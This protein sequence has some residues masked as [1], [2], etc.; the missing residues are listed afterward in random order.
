M[1]QAKRAAGFEKITIGDTIQSP[2]SGET[3]ELKFIDNFDGDSLNMDWWSYNPMVFDNMEEEVYLPENV[4]VE[5]SHLILTARKTEEE[6]T[7]H[8]HGNVPY[9]SHYTS[10][11]IKSQGKVAFKFG[12]IEMLARLPYSQGMWP[13]FWMMGE[14]RGWPWGGEIDIME[15]VGGTD[16]WNNFNRDGTISA[17][18]HWCDPDLEPKDAWGGKASHSGAGKYDMPGKMEGE[19]LADAYHVIGIEWTDKKITAYIDD[20]PYGS[21]DIDQ[22]PTM[23]EAF[24]KEHFMLLNLAVGGGWAGSPDSYS[25]TVWPQKYMIDWVKVWQIK[26]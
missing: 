5:D 13:A 19:K 18:L 9:T 22:D 1:E 14:A 25:P 15:M 2:I 7:G 17:A 11:A 8:K 10:G 20:I 24:F 12:R 3:Y 6:Y 23:R 21:H 4:T 26:E 16:Q